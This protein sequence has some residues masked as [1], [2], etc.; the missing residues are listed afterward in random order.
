MPVIDTWSLRILVA[1]ADHGSFTSAAEALVLTQP[2]V[3]RQI[4]GLER[5][6]AVPLF[7]RVPRGVVPTAAGETAVRL[8]REL[9]AQTDSFEATMR[10]FSEVDGGRLCLSGFASVNTNFVPDAIRRFAHQHPSV[11]VTLRHI[12]PLDALSAVRE[13]RVDVALVTDWQLTDDP[14]AARVDAHTP[15]LDVGEIPGVE[16]VRLIDE[17]FRVALPVG[18]RLADRR[19]IALAELRDERWVDG[20]F[21]DCLGP[22]AQLAAALGGEPQI[23][24]FCDDWN[25]KQALV[26]GGAGI[27]LVPTLAGALIRPD[28]VLRTTVPELP[29]RRLFAATARPP[30]RT[31]PAEAM[32]AVLTSLA[33]EHRTGASPRPRGDAASQPGLPPVR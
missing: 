2:A 7:R 23:D 1:V 14:W 6:F 33:A 26:A 3:S 15:M 31:P 24:F 32:L 12:D 10:S 11:T 28:L 13:G 22:L 4:N 21:P 17:E 27:M 5:Q 16:L 30:F 29:P 20:A 19:P 18:H 25:G 8:A 9:L